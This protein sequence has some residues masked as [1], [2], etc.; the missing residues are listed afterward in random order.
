MLNGEVR[1]PVTKKTKKLYKLKIRAYKIKDNFVRKIKKII[2]KGAVARFRRRV[3]V[4]FRRIEEKFSKVK[5]NS[6]YKSFMPWISYLISRGLT[7]L[8]MYT[9]LSLTANYFFPLLRPTWSSHML[10]EIEIE[11]PCKLNFEKLLDQE[12][13][14]HRIENC[15]CDIE[16]IRVLGYSFEVKEFIIDE[17]VPNH[18]SRFIDEKIHQKIDFKDLKVIFEKRSDFT[19][20]IKGKAT[21]KDRPVEIEGYIIFSSSKGQ[22]LIVSYSKQQSFAASVAR[23]VIHSFIRGQFHYV[24]NIDPKSRDMDF[25]S[26]ARFGQ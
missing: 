1:D 17:D 23:R 7:V 11:V 21:F 2:Y 4:R 19:M 12:K 20:T 8:V 26:Q 24:L 6:I 18:L 3:I 5:D 15:S 16:S 25:Q 22:A 14:L 9:I 13:A 10:G